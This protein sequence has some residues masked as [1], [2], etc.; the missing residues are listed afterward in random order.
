MLRMLNELSLPERT[1]LHPTQKER[2]EDVRAARDML[3]TRFIP[4]GHRAITLS[5]DEDTHF[6]RY[7]TAEGALKHVGGAQFKM[8]APLIQAL[9]TARLPK[10]RRSVP[11]HDTVV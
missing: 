5:A 3:S 9:L 8:R 4:A 1:S 10:L 11:S 6:A 2:V 7:L